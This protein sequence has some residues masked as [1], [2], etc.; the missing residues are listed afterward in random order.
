MSATAERGMVI[1]IMSLKG[2]EGQEHL[3][4]LRIPGS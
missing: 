4:I 2:T 1:Q 3:H